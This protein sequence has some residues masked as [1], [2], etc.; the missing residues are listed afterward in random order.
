M[1]LTCCCEILNGYTI[2]KKNIGNKKVSS[3]QIHKAKKNEQ[4]YAMKEIEIDNENYSE[5]ENEDKI[6]RS[7]EHHNIVKY[8]ESFTIVKNNK[9]YII[10]ELCESDLSTFI[11]NKNNELID[12]KVIYIILKDICF[13]LK[14]LH[15]NNIIHRD[16]KPGKYFNRLWQKI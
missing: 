15:S 10:M 4:Y 6:L 7:F 1:G 16:L 5:I 8:I 3:G 9:Y 11:N 2:V 13:G 12:E 14:E